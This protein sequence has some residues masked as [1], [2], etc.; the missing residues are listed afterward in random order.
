MVEKCILDEG[1]IAGWD[2]LGAGGENLLRGGLFG[3]KYVYEVSDLYDA[4][5]GCS[6]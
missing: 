3:R 2:G 5:V 1:G 6:L 4:R